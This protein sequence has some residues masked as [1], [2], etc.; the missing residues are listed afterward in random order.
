MLW[1]EKLILWGMKSFQNK[2][3]GMKKMVSEFRKIPLDVKYALLKM[4]LK[5]VR[6]KHKLAFM[7]WRLYFSKIRMQS[8]EH[9]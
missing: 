4:Y 9:C 7:Q 6:L 5:Q 2:D 3:A 8:E 1:E